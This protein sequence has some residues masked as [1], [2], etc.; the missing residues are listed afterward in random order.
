[1][2][3]TWGWLCRGRLLNHRLIFLL[4]QIF[5]WSLGA[6][7]RE[8]DITDVLIKLNASLS[9]LSK[10]SSKFPLHNVLIFLSHCKGPSR[11]KFLPHLLSRLANPALRL[12]A[13]RSLQISPSYIMSTSNEIITQKQ[14][15]H[16]LREITEHQMRYKNFISHLYIP[17][18][19]SIN[20]CLHMLCIDRLT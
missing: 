12:F 19:L 15:I 9:C 14:N 13:M 3:W 2:S 4:P 20:I 6:K 10:S 7:F 16:K 5:C 1:M 18:S 11:G 17:V 8:V